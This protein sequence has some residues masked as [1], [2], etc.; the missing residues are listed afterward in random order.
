MSSHSE[1]VAKCLS[2]VPGPVNSSDSSVRSC[3]V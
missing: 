2:F 3:K 1:V